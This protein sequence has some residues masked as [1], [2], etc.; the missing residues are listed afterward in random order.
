[1]VDKCEYSLVWNLI[2]FF[3]GVC[4]FLLG[5]LGIFW[6][7]ATISDDLERYSTY[8]DYCNNRIEVCYCSWGEC[9]FRSM[10]WTRSENGVQI[11]SGMDNQTKEL[12][13]LAT[14]LNDKETL[15]KVGCK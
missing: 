4:L 1:M 9:T 5:L 11:S 10:T 8:K 7:S 12:C 2:K 15:F 13:D 14:K 3:I 6:L